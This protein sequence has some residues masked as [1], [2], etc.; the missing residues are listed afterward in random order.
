MNKTMVELFAGVGGIRLGLERLHSGWKTVWFSQWEPSMKKQWAHECYINHFGDCVDINGE[1]HTNDDITIVDKNTIPN[2]ILLTGGFPCLTADTLVLT[3]SGYKPFIEV[4]VGD[5][6]LSHDGQW[7][8]V[9]AFMEQGK[10]EVYNIKAT[11]I[12]SVKATKNHQFYVRKCIFVWDNE[13]RRYEKKLLKPEWQPIEELLHSSIKERYYLACPINQKSIVPVWNGLS[14]YRNRTTIKTINTLDLHSVD[15]WYLIGRYLGDGWLRK[16]C[17]KDNLCRYTYTGVI[18]CCNK[19]ETDELQERIERLFHCS[20]AREKTVNK[21][22]ISNIEFASFLEQFGLYAYGKV[23]PSFV[24]DLPFELLRSFIEGY[25]DADGYYNKKS[26][27]YKIASINLKLLYGLAYC[28]YKVYGT[29]CSIQQTHIEKKYKI[30]GRIVNQHNCYSLE[31]RKTCQKR[32]TIL[33]NGFIWL[34]IKSIVPCGTELVYDIEVED[35]HSFIANGCITHNCQSFS[36]AN[37]LARSKGL[38]GDKGILWWQIVDTIQAKN[39]P[40]CIFENVDRILKS[41]ASQRGRDFG[42]ILKSL[43]N[44][45]YS[46]EWRVVNAA[47]YGAGQRRRRIFVF[48]YRNDTK[49]AKKTRIYSIEKILAVK[50]FMAKAF[51][52]MEIGN[53]KEINIFDTSIEDISRDFKFQFLSAGYMVNGCIYTTEVKEQ[54][55]K[56]ILLGDL[57]E[58]TNE[59]KYFITDKSKLEKWKYL[60]GA[61]KL[62]RKAKNGYEYTYSEGPVAFPDAWDKP[63]RTMLTSEGTVNR[64]SHVVENPVNRKLR[65]LLPIEAE[66]LQGF[67]DNW[68]NTGMSDRMRYFCMGNALVVPMITRMGKVLDSIIEKEDEIR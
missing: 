40:F 15:L 64:S 38:E 37:T 55:E 49:Y 31:F 16:Q 44:L 7:H 12:L 27:V 25:I 58:Y 5:E 41:P 11:G 67:D 13:I 23:I 4:A 66:R 56:P 47:D 42:V 36:V 60:K 8:T 22:I 62:Q 32:N 57:L 35:S 45:N 59:S 20:I 10:K 34:P 19:S 54:K 18:I 50:G 9:T 14:Y 3:K 65:I 1:Y 6:V 21:L 29:S 63:G 61:K 26:N 39:P 33:D 24:F 46:V 53:I 51:P 48:A 17:K 30:E 43:S 2:C 28:I 68:T 52:V